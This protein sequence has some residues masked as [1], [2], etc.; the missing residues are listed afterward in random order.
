MSERRGPFL[1]RSK[2]CIYETPWISVH[3]HQVSLPDGSDSVYGVVHV[4]NRAIGVLPLHVDGTVT[5]VGQHRFPLDAYSWECPEGGCP[6]GEDPLDAAKRELKEET[7][8]TAR[9][10][11][12]LAAFDVSNCVTDEKSECFLAWDLTEGTASPEPTEDLTLKRL[13]FRDLLAMCLEGEIRDGLTLVM[14]LAASARAR[15]GELPEEAAAL[16]S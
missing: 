7:G 1:I 2:S 11:R 3:D 14:V 6:A 9:E 15:R 12:P 8:L 5:I 4:K 10:W 13:P 16:L